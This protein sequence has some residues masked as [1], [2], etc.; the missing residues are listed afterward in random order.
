MFIDTPCLASI[1][2]LRDENIKDLSTFSVSIFLPFEENASFH[3]IRIFH[4]PGTMS[5]RE[6][7]LVSRLACQPP[8]D[9]RWP[10][11]PKFISNIFAPFYYYLLSFSSPLNQRLQTMKADAAMERPHTL[12]G[13]WEKHHVM[14]TFSGQKRN[15]IRSSSII[16]PRSW[17]PRRSWCSHDLGAT[18]LANLVCSSSCTSRP[19][20]LICLP[21]CWSGSS[22]SLPWFGWPPVN[23]TLQRDGITHSVDGLQLTWTI[24][25][26]LISTY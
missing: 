15:V 1:V 17:L 14:V 4:C 11:S 7:Q 8:V 3:F 10:F 12:A 2:L 19:Y 23:L 16:S 25:C 18:R 5:W 6:W 22:S 24:K 20:A 13:R 9:A 26:K 21:F